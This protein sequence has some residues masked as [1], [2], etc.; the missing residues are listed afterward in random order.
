MVY[1]PILVLASTRPEYLFQLI[2]WLVNT[3]IFIRLFASSC[4]LCGNHM[5]C[6]HYFFSIY[7]RHYWINR[8]HT[9]MAWRLEEHHCKNVQFRVGNLRQ[10]QSRRAWAVIRDVQLCLIDSVISMLA[11]ERTRCHCQLSRYTSTARNRSFQERDMYACM[12][13][14]PFLSQF[15]GNQWPDW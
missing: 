5:S 6:N 12:I 7:P 10:K 15:W 13:D 8:E 4:V 9:L 14:P 3:R 11:V 2:T 1:T